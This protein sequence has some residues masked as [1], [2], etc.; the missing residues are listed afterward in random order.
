MSHSSSDHQER[1]KSNEEDERDKPSVKRKVCFNFN[2]GLEDLAIRDPAGNPAWDDGQRWE[3]RGKSNQKSMCWLRCQRRGGIAGCFSGG[4]LAAHTTAS[5][6]MPC[7][8]FHGLKGR[9]G[10]A[11]VVKVNKRLRRGGKQGKKSCMHPQATKQSEERFFLSLLCSHALGMDASGLLRW[12]SMCQ[13]L[14]TT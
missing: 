2:S 4:M 14:A 7:L 12:E 8:S 11:S 5:H 1:G 6:R 13:A 9:R 3:F 10:R